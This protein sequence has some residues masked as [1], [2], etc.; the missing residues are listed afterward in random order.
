MRRDEAVVSRVVGSAAAAAWGASLVGCFEASVI[1][2]SGGGLSEYGL[3]P[4][5]F[6]AY[7]ALGVTL[8][9]PIVVVGPWVR[10]RWQQPEGALQALTS[11]AVAFPITLVVARYHLA[12]RYFGEQM[13]APWSGVGLLLYPGLVVCAL[14]V[15]L[16]IAVLVVAVRGRGRFTSVRLGASWA[17]AFALLTVG[18]RALR[19]E[20]P[21]PLRQARATKPSPNVVLFVVDTLRADALGIAGGQAKTPHMDALAADGVW[22]RDAYAQSSWTRPSIATILTGEYPAVHGAVHKFDPLPED[23]ETLAERLRAAGYWTA[24]FVTNIN[25]APIFNFD[26]G[27]GEYHYL[28]PSFYF[29]ASDSA[30]RLSIYKLLRLLRERFL[31]R[32]IYYYHYYQ[33]AAVVTDHV[34]RWLAESP[35]EPFFLFIHY[36]DPHD[37]YFEIPYNGR[38]I[39]RVAEP[40]PPP[41]RA[42]EMRRL[43]ASDVAY[44][45]QHFGALIERFRQRGLYERTL[46]VLTADH[47]EEFYEHGGWWHGT[48]LY[49]EQIRV[50]LIIRLPAGANRAQQRTDLAQTLDIVPT[51]LAQAGLPVPHELPGRDLFSNR[52]QP[53]VLYAHESLEGNEIEALRWGPWKLIVANEG[54]PRGLPRV[55]LFHL[56]DDPFEQADLRGRHPEIVQE[57]SAK[58]EKFRGDVQKGVRNH[59]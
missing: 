35:P 2:L 41:E 43:Y 1:A 48:T 16:L 26:Q 10:A 47:G 53:E 15:S 33:D 50:P 58:L 20:E 28:A 4:F 12:Q 9:L 22:F 6:W 23:M 29:G 18:A 37:P 8:S 5:G 49:E 36:M 3:F 14:L 40:N 59:R 51:V 39:A 19:V 32:R 57:L 56:I 54:N 52:E 45:D 44:F 7:A 24:A 55:A 27:F 31:H 11:G 30:T 42:E 21:A 38:G 34:S 46:F 13:P 25:V 17:V